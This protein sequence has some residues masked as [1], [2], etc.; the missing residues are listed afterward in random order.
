MNKSLLIWGLVTQVLLLKSMTVYDF[1]DKHYSNDDTS[2]QEWLNDRV[3]AIHGE[4][5]MAAKSRD[6]YK[7]T[8]KQ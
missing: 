7:Y 8:V 1:W 2:L 4:G 3:T 5:S 6:D